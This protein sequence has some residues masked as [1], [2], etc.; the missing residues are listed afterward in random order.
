[1]CAHD[2]WPYAFRVVADNGLT[3]VITVTAIPTVTE[4]RNLANVFQRH[5]ATGAYAYEFLN[6]PTI[7]PG[8]IQINW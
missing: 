7:P 3:H 4:T 8:E 6:K 2:E 5:G 1:V